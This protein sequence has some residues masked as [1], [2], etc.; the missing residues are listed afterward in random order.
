MQPLDFVFEGLGF[1][2]NYSDID[3]STHGPQG[4]QLSGNLYGIAPVMWN[5]TL[6][7]ENSVAS[8]RVSY[9][10]SDSFPTS[11]LNENGVTYAR[12]Y[13]YDKDQLDLSASYTFDNIGMDW[14]QRFRVS[15]NITNLT[16]I[17][18]PADI[19]VPGSP[20]SGG[21]TYYPLAPRMFFVTVSAAL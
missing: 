9:N 21:Y 5:T 13:F 7:W 18:G 10:H 1:M 12:R 3:L 20:A 11:G 17:K 15:G 8:V 19:S 16:D 2:A 4:S 6:Y 14:L